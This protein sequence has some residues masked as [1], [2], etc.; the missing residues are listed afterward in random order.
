M[1]VDL[2][3]Y[4]RVTYLVSASN[5]FKIKLV[6]LSLHCFWIYYFASRASYHLHKH[7]AASALLSARVDFWTFSCLN[8]ASTD[9][10]RTFILIFACICGGQL[11]SG[12]DSYIAAVYEH[13]VIL[14]P[15][16]R[17]PL[18]RLD[19]LRH[20][21]RNLDIYEEQAAL[22]ALQVWI[23]NTDVFRTS[24]SLTETFT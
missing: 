23:Q 12:V 9:K 14:N 18:S 2:E 15:E 10:M 4:F 5:L 19:A 1:E 3:K 20:M 17:V 13:K 7:Q 8:A 6:W 21:Q 16:P 22:A 24:C 11:E